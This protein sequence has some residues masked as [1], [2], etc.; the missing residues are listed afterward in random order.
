VQGG[1]LHTSQRE[2]VDVFPVVGAGHVLLSETNGVL[3][4]CDTVENFK[5]DFRDALP[6]QNEQTGYKKNAI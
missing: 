1:E 5:I 2:R 3:A 6:V 4:L